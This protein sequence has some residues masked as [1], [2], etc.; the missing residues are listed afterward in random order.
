MTKSVK[1]APLQR[2]TQPAS[3]QDGLLPAQHIAAWHNDRMMK[4]G[5]LRTPVSSRAAVIPVSLTVALMLLSS[6]AAPATQP[7]PPSDRPRASAAA[8]L[9]PDTALLKQTMAAALTAVAAREEKPEQE[10]LRS[11][12]VSTGITASSLEVSASRTP[13]GLDVDAMEAAARTGGDCV[14]GQLRDDA[15]TMTVLPVLANGKCLAGDIH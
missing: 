14:I 5:S 4:E 9:N 10:S 8:S 6:C 11:E 15:V 7:T 1:N 13:T 2:Q 12:L 3:S